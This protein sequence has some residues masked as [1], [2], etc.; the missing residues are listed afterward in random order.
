MA[1]VSVQAER[2]N[3]MISEAEGKIRKNV[4]AGIA[5]L[6][7]VALAVWPSTQKLYGGMSIVFASALGTWRTGHQS[8]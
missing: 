5:L 6:A 7:L 2:E 4:G 1:P 3:R 8:L